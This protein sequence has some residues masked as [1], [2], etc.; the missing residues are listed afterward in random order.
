M[1]AEGYLE[2]GLELNEGGRMIRALWSA[3]EGMRHTLSTLGMVGGV[4]YLT[5]AVC[6]GAFRCLKAVYRS[7]SASEMEELYK[8]AQRAGCESDPVCTTFCIICKET[9]QG[10]ERRKR[11]EMKRMVKEMIDEEILATKGHLRA[12][13]FNEEAQARR[14][15]RDGVGMG[16]MEMVRLQQH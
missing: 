2:E 3:W 6:G 9:L 1:G 10:P 4:V 11:L 15:S 14:S 8:G 13:I 16:D 12:L 7:R 5:K